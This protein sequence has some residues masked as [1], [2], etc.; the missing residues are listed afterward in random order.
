MKELDEE[1][2]SVSSQTL[3]ITEGYMPFLGHKTY[4]RVVGE[5]QKGKD[6]VILL[7]GGPGSTHN[8]FEL[9]NELATTGHQ[10]VMYD[11][12]GCGNSY[13]DGHPELW[14]QD[15]WLDEMEALVKHLKIEKYHLLGQSWGGMMAIAMCCDRDA[16]QIASVILSSANPS[17]SLWS[18]EQHRQIRESLSA[19]EQEAIFRAEETGN[20]EDP[21]Y[22]EANDHYMQMFCAGPYTEQ[23]PECL[24]RPK[25]AGKESYVYGWGPNEY[26]PTG[27][28][29]NFEYLEKMKTM[30]VPTLVI[31]G[32]SDLCTT[33]IAKAM[34]DNLPNSEWIEFEGSRHMPFADDTQHYIRVIKDWLRRRG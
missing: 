16:T 31:N 33:K 28:L 8:Y 34:H 21:A 4:Y 10:L 26:V 7:H 15:V 18:D 32:S 12:I 6:P 23:D 5:R 2:I 11:Q 17:A 22:L 1:K 3:T 30:T 25:Q 20:F 19:E 9:L 29:G 24:W 13:L 14:T 27:S